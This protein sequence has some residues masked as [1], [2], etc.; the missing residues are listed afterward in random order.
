M[1]INLKIYIIVSTDKLNCNSSNLLFKCCLVKYSI[2]S[3]PTLM[4]FCLVPLCEGHVPSQCVSGPEV[5]GEQS[6]QWS[7]Q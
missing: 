2:G 6:I 1:G 5:P 3:Q 7:G 4:M